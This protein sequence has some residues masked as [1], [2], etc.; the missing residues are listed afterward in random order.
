V[1]NA[2]LGRLRAA[3]RYGRFRA[4]SPVT[5]GGAPIIIHSKVVIVDDTALRI[6]SS[7]MNNRSMGFDSECDICISTDDPA[8]APRATEIIQGFRY[9]LLAEHL[10]TK[11]EIVAAEETRTGS[12]IQTIES[13]NP[14]TG[15]HLAAVDETKVSIL[16]NLFISLQLLDPLS[17]DD[18]WRPWRRARAVSCSS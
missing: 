15:R 18:S 4:F 2:L 12:L 3:D 10:A 6:G 8:Q 11:P 14:E 13:R 5:A 16:D 7:N 1:R 9:R 17:R